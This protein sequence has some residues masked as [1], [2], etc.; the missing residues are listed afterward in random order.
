MAYTFN[1]FN[2]VKI[3]IENTWFNFYLQA[4]DSTFNFKIQ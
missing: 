1:Y 4:K 3:M 2:T